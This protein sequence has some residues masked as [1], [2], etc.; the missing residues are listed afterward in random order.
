MYKSEAICLT[1]WG[2]YKGQPGTKWPDCF[3]S[4][5]ECMYGV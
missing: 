3:N 4:N 1:G 2:I 5:A